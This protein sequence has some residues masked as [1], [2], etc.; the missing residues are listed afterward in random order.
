MDTGNGH[1]GGLYKYR[2]KYL[3]VSKD[4][5][6]RKENKAILQVVLYA[7]QIGRVILSLS[8]CRY[9]QASSGLCSFCPLYLHN[10]IETKCFTIV[11]I[12]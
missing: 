1:I 7:L 3:S 2:M 4:N 10:F 5:E 11:C 8:N 9:K 12:C 6:E